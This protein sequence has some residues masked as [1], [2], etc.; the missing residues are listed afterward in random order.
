MGGPI[1]YAKIEAS[2]NDAA[3]D[4]AP[5][6]ERES[7]AQTA[8][9][10]NEVDGGAPDAEVRGDEAHAIVDAIAKVD[11][12]PRDGSGCEL[13]CD[14]KVFVTAKALPSGGFGRGLTAPA[15]AFC[16]GA[17]DERSL[18]G[19]WRAW[20]SNAVDSPATRFARTT[21]AYRLLD[22]TA[23]AMGWL[24]LTSG[25]LLHAIDMTEMGTAIPLTHLMEVWTGTT[26]S[27]TASGIS[28]ADWTN[29][30][31]NLPYGDIGTVGKI[32]N[33]WTQNYRQYC[34]FPNIHLYCFE[35]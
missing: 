26:P 12:G 8:P 29:S 21:G 23:V 5:S 28:C 27:G 30:T 20:V 15:D 33:A 16:Q 6:N 11:G 14:K 18:G 17:A 22:G 7:D 2:T 4:A 1:A 19:T 35:Q 24:G 32:D 10:A 13:G 9:D 25:K 31:S 3:P 34:S